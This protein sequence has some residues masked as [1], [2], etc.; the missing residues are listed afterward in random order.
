MV[1][2]ELV[3]ALRNELV[4]LRREFHQNPELGGEE[5]HTSLRIQEYLSS[6]GLCPHVISKTG[7]TALIHGNGPGPTIMLRSDMDALPLNEETNLP[8]ASRNPGIMHACAH[9]GHMAVLLIAAKI[10]MAHREEFHG[11]VK[12]VFQP[13]EETAGALDMIREGVL[14]SP[15]PDYALG[16]HLWSPLPTGTLGL[17]AGPVMAAN[18]AF[19]IRIKGKG[20]HSGSPE[21]TADPI[22]AASSVIQALQSIQTREISP[23]RP[24]T[25]VVCQMQAGSAPNIIPEYADLAGSIRYLYQGDKGSQEHPLQR[26]E[27]I[28]KDVCRTY[29]TSCDVRFVPSNPCVLNHEYVVKVGRHAAS[30]IGIQNVVPYVTMAGEDFGEFAVRVPSAFCFVGAGNAEKGADYPHHHPK[31]DIDEDALSW[32]A[33]WL[34]ETALTLLNKEVM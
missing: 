24:T 22:L 32:G 2:V 13:N 5:Y 4:A 33:S 12:L 11:T 6:I 14:E 21:T 7:V 9:D 15:T 29:G 31:F 3:S 18:D 17:S 26:L 19:F 34:C 30:Q 28:S 25:I 1:I 10:L 23:L 8:F 16:I 20:G 27:R